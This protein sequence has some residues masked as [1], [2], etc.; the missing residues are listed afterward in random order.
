MFLRVFSSHVRSIYI[1]LHVNW[2]SV[3]PIKHMCSWS[4]GVQRGDSTVSG[5]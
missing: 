3:F 5:P 2:V 1:L 4:S